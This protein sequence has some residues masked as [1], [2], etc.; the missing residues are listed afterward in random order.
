VWLLGAPCVEEELDGR[1]KTQR[2]E[3]EGGKVGY[4]LPK[5][6]YIV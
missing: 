6:I 3:R 1:R 2:E 4:T 5:K